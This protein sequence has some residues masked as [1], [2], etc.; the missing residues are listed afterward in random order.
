M[1]RKINI[2]EIIVVLALAV[3]ILML[4]LPHT[5]RAKELSR[6]LLCMT[7]QRILSQAWLAY[8]EEY[9]GHLVGGSTYYRGSR[10]TPYRWVERPLYKPDDNPEFDP[11]PTDNELTHEYRLNGIKAGEL[12]PY[13]GNTSVYHCPAS[14]LWPPQNEP[15]AVY[16]S[17]QVSG[18]MNSEDFIYREGWPGTI[19]IYRTIF[20]P[21]GTRQ[22]LICVEKYNQIKNPVKK[23]VLVEEDVQG[24]FGQLFPAGGFVLMSNMNFWSWWDWPA[25]FHNGQATFGF[26]DGHAETHR[27]M[28]N[29]TIW[30]LRGYDNSGKSFSSIIHPDNP[31]L[32]W[33]NR[34]YLVAK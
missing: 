30:L 21:D 13:I 12:F 20:F 24:A 3:F 7:N 34:G 28:D 26:A 22:S 17:Y 11:M 19:S 27:W 25:G 2:P 16:L 18:T 15:H 6:I 10:A 33:M 5:G 32:E 4:F 9:D 29:R 23:Y 31:D 8:Q 1:K 14:R